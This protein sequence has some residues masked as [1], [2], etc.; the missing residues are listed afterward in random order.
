MD[1]LELV[2]GFVYRI[3]SLLNRILISKEGASAAVD[4]AVLYYHNNITLR[5]TIPAD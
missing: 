2:I 5:A 3:L 4:N 1:F